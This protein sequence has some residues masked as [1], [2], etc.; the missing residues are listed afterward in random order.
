[1]MAVVLLTARDGG[2]V[3][4]DEY[5][6]EVDRL[7]DYLLNNFTIT[8]GK[9][10]IKYKDLCAPYCNMNAALRLFKVHL[11]LNK[12]VFFISNMQFLHF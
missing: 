5:F 9:E 10:P 4:R 2:S 12:A 3:L 8:C 6:D 1:M 11:R 7:N